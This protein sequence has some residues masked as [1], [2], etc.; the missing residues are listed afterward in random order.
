[1][2][3]H[4]VVATVLADLDTAPIAEPLRATLRF[5]R[6]VTRHHQAVD[7]ADVHALFG[8]GLTRRH[9]EDALAVCFAFNVI[10]R[11]ADTFEFEVGSAESFD[12]G[13]KHLLSRGYR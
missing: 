9:V 5:L 11:L 4:E 7:P 2:L 12:A 3:G 10:T 1:V 6:K 8:L 13:A